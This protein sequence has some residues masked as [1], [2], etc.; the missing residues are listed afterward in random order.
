MNFTINRMIRFSLILFLFFRFSLV[1]S[2]TFVFAQLNGTPNINTTGWNLTG[3]AYAGDTGG[4]ADSSPNELILTNASGN[5]SGGVFYGTAINPA[6]CSKWTV[7]FDYRIWGGS[8]AD[9]LAFCFLDVPPAGFVSGGGVGIP[10][11]ANGLKVILD[12][13][14][15]CGGPNPELQIYSGVGYNEC[16]AGIV[17]LDNSAGNLGFVRNN[18]YQPVKITYLNGV[19]TLFIN[20]IQYLTGNFPINF[21]G[22]MGFTASTGGSTD[23][24]SIRNVI[25]YTDQAIS[26]A[27]PDV[28]FC[29]SNSSQIGSTNNTTYLYN[30]SPSNGLSS[31]TVSNPTVSLTNTGNTPITQ[32]YTVS[33][34]LATSPGVCSTTDQVSVTVY[35]HLSNTVNAS[36]CEGDSYNF[37]GQSLTS[38]GS[39]TANFTTVNGC[40]SI[41]NLNLT[42]NP[43]IAITIDTTI[44]Q[45]SVVQFGGQNLNSAGQFVFN[46]Q[47][48]G[49]CDS[50]LTVNLSINSLPVISAS[51][52]EICFGEQVTLIPNGAINYSWQPN[53][54]QLGANGEITVSPLNTT[55]Y[56]LTGTDAN[57]CSI[58]ISV[59]VSV[60][61]LPIIN[62]VSNS[63]QYCV[64]NQI[65]L[66]AS[67]GIQYIW[68]EFPLN[69]DSQQTT[70][71]QQSSWYHVNGIDI[72]GCQATDSLFILVNA[73]PILTITP[74]QSICLGEAAS[75]LVNGASSYIWSPAGSGNSFTFSPTSSTTYTI[76]GT[77]NNNC[78]SEITSTII[79][80]PNPSAGLT[81]N[82]SI[83]TS[84]SPF[85]TFTNTSVGANIC[86]IDLGDQT[87]FDVFNEPIEHAYPFTEGN[88]SVNLWVSNSFGCTD[89][90]ELFVQIK[91][92]EL[93][94]IPNTFTPD[95]DEHNNLFNPIFTAG[96]DPANFQMDIYNRWG[97]LIFQSFNA[98]KGWDGFYQ[99]RLCPIG[100]YSWKITYKNPDIDEYK[101]ITGHVNLLK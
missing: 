87:V 37:D 91:G 15:N 72:N 42:V 5:Q 100:S 74:D 44:C 101:V 60:N 19:V 22:Y 54:G 30:W 99:G 10:G 66:I 26:N 9:G 70:I 7:E 96:F 77:D 62:L 46:L 17:K 81:V 58:S 40:D 27:G 98:E 31:T 11:T 76:V 80:H 68:G 94:Y 64:G 6:I 39:Y 50:T 2:Q 29:S 85:V 95:G 36:I 69:S 89:S 53:Q 8:A 48:S 51:N 33:T 52:E 88:Y 97:E 63:N 18:N 13:W 32:V 16:I 84:D 86:I 56:T 57:N 55:N 82:P 21:S 4:D 43:N 14:N 1:I 12:T 38:S 35:P 93:F 61:P 25:I 83:T 47:T 71:A 78:S 67:G 92:D 90:I 3:N 49:G 41:V 65:Q 34:S 79:V 45:G 23:Q 28:S 75:I 20:N 59:L 24:H 73:N